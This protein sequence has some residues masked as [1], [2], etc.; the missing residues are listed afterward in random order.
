MY[1]VP[2]G[3]PSGTLSFLRWGRVA[4]SAKYSPE[5]R[6]LSPVDFCCSCRWLYELSIGWKGLVPRLERSLSKGGKCSFLPKIIEP[7]PVKPSASG[8]VLSSDFFLKGI[9]DLNAVI[10]FFCFSISLL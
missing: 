2:E 6:I 9:S 10:A 4:L 1:S 5:P 8:R 3:I 7:F